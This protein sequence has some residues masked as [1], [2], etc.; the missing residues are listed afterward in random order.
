MLRNRGWNRPTSSITPKLTS[1][2]IHSAPTIRQLDRQTAILQSRQIWLT[3][4][5]CK[6]IV[7]VS[8]LVRRISQSSY[9]IVPRRGLHA[10]TISGLRVAPVSVLCVSCSVCYASLSK[11]SF[12]LPFSVFRPL[13]YP[14]TVPSDT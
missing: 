14:P 10:R 4:S 6:M 7:A 5:A 8:D 12:Y 2:P 13:Q 1:W 11:V 3:V 9:E